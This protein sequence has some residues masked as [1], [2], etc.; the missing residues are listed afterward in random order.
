V[1]RLWLGIATVGLI[2]VLFL[3]TCGG[4]LVID[5]P[6]HADVI[7]A[8]AGETERR[9]ERAV[10]LL[11]QGFATRVIL[12]VPKDA[13]IYSRTELQ[14]AHEYILTL[15][16]KCA[17]DICPIEGLST[18]AEAHDAAK[19]LQ[20]WPVHSVLLVT[21][22][23]HTRRALSTFSHDLPQYRFSIAAA[24][25]PVQFGPHWWKHRQWAKQNLGEWFRL[26]WWEVVDRWR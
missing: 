10:E 4:F 24:Y 15:P 17:I 5:K 21:S 16:Q 26:A 11:S 23:F 3:T 22:D 25:D 13:R 2:L 8:L 6:E 12:N 19:C 9:P 18:N 1:R 14:L 7:M 20:G